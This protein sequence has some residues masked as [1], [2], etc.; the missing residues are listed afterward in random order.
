M[1]KRFFNKKVSI[2]E[3]TDPDRIYV[4]NVRSFFNISTRLAKYLCKIAVRQGIFRKKIAVECKNG[5]CTR[6]IEVFDK[7]EDIPENIKCF[8]CELEGESEYTFRTS[9]LNIVEFYQYIENG[10]QKTS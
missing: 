4:E 7:E 10:K 2:V 3:E 5:N 1:F 8:M 6:I 9:E